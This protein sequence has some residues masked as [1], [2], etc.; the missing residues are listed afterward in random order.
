MGTLH[1]S[2]RFSCEMHLETEIE[3]RVRIKSPSRE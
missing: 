1:L 2:V 3:I